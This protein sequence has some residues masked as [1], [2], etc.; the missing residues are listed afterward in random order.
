MRGQ[1][2][3]PLTL[4]QWLV[5]MAITVPITEASYR[6]IETPIRQ[7]RLGEWLHG[8]RRPRTAVAY[9]RRQRLTAVGIA[10][11]A[12]V[13]FAGV[14]IAMAGNQCVGQ[15]ECDSQAGRAID[16]TPTLPIHVPSTTAVPQ[17]EIP[18]F[19]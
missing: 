13:G 2:G 17:A 18:V 6:Y 19:V 4:K 16:L 11:A 7:G 12:L 5:A 3:V 8:H 10:S 1:A 14:S 15:I 9:K